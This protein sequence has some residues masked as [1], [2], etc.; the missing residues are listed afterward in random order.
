MS[1]LGDWQGATLQL[2]PQLTLQSLNG[3]SLAV[4]AFP[5]SDC[6]LDAA[7]VQSIDSIG[8][9]AILSLY[10]HAEKRGVKLA[11]QSAS[12]HMLRLLKV[13]QLDGALLDSQ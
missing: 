7:Q 5:A 12:P 10:R 2:A 4:S 6:V 9:A 11:L 13:Y 3:Q 8:I 1:A